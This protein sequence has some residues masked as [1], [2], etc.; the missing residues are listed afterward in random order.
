MAGPADA[1]ADCHRL[2]DQR[3][4]EVWWNEGMCLRVYNGRVR[5]T[6]IME[7]ID[8]VHCIAHVKWELRMKELEGLYVKDRE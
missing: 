8:V 3:W 1:V 4:K 5:R 7:L 6:R 2:V